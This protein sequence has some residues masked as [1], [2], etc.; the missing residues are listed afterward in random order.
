VCIVVLSDQNYSVF[1]VD[2]I[3]ALYYEDLAARNIQKK[4]KCG[5][6]IGYSINENV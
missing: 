1:L 4:E 3:S 6:G 2:L 5:L